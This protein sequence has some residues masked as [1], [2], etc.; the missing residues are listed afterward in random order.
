MKYPYS[1]FSSNFFSGYFCC[2]DPYVVRMVSGRCYLSFFTPIYIVFESSCRCINAVF[3]AGK[4]S[5]SFLIRHFFL[6][7]STSFLGCKDLYIVI[8]FLVLWSIHWNSCLTFRNSPEYLTRGTALT[9][10]PL[11]KFLL[12][13]FVSSSFLVLLRYSFL[14]FSFI[15]TCL[16]PIF[17]NV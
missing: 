10:I 2:V 3:N 9:I 8:S 14:I 11:M 15:A 1:C 4:S 17:L 7:L 13:I 5:S 6:L 12:Y 16:I